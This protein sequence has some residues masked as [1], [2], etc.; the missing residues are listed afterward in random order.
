MK[1]LYNVG[2]DEPT[3]REQ[4]RYIRERAVFAARRV[5]VGRRL[6]PIAGPL[7]VGVQVFGYDTLSEVSDARIDVGWPGAESLDIVNLART[8]VAIPN[9]HKEFE[10]NKLDL[11]ASQMTGR[12]LN[13]KN[14]ES[15][16][17]KVGLEEDKLIILGWSRDGTAYDINGLY[18]A[19]GN[20]ENTALDYGTKANIE[21]SINNAIAL[22]LV[23]NIYPPYNLTLHPTQ[24]AQT[25]AL[26]ANTAKSYRDWIKEVIMGEVFVTPAMTAGDGML[27]AVNAQG[28][29]EF[30]LA[31]D[32]SVDT[33]ILAKSKNLFGKVYVRGLPVVY[34]SNAICKLSDI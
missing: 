31:E 29:F 3:T 23:D 28:M 7:G 5:M 13:V 15:A 2:R 1:R 22:L 12:P 9:I 18:N 27:S 6:T 19:A 30:V 4:G 20:D 8:T 17:Y 11:A 16:S 33:E 21:T 25:L 10:I 14:A 26:I 32:L 24:Y 34:D